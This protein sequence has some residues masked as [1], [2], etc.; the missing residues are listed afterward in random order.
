MEP[1]FSLESCLFG[2]LWPC[3][4]TISPLFREHHPHSPGGELPSPTRVPGFQE[5]RTP[6]S[7]PRAPDVTRSRQLAY[8][9]VPATRI[10]S[11]PAGSS[12]WATQRESEACGEAPGRAPLLPCQCRQLQE[13][14]VQGE[15]VRGT[16]PGREPV[17]CEET[18]S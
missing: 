6:L 17:R 2:L 16:L 5:G 4:P 10:G 9:M 8:S 11:G 1:F 14:M 15:T 3:L 7:V 13:G 18:D 12:V